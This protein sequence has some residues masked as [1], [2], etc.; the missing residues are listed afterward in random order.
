MT[1]A[2]QEHR[3]DGLEPGN[4]LG[5]LALLGLLRALEA[6]RSEWRPRAFWDVKNPPLR[7]VL[8]LSVPQSQEAVCEAA[9]KGVERLMASL[10]FGDATDLKIKRED[11]RR[12][13]QSA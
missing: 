8:A 11:A 3:L 2:S 1:Q 13:S 10:D 4:L 12:L 6:E 5:F 7:P 9:A